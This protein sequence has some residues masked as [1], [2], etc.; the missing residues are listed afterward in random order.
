M[1]SRER[2]RRE[3]SMLNCDT[4]MFYFKE[5]SC[6]GHR[7]LCMAKVGSKTWLGTE[8]SR[9]FSWS[10]VFDRYLRSLEASFRAN[11]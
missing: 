9:P 8:V 7:V 11:A 10:M 5:E 2:N 1:W 6:P 4:G 3:Y